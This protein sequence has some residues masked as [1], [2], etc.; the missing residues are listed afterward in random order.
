ME[1]IDIHFTTSGT[2]GEEFYKYCEG[3]L[4]AL[5]IH[6]HLKGKPQLVGPVNRDLPGDVFCESSSPQ[7]A[8]ADTHRRKKGDVADA[9]REFGNQTWREALAMRK[10]DT[11]ERKIRFLEENESR[12]CDSI[13]SEKTKRLLYK[14]T[15][16]QRSTPKYLFAAR[17]R[18]R[19]KDPQG[20]SRGDRYFEVEETT[21]V[22]RSL[23]MMSLG[24]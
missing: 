2:N 7:E 16:C 20:H 8:G 14:I 9:I 6:L 24:F 22:G 11:E 17:K 12:A 18:G 3:L 1:L 5:Y 15:L 13:Y 10:H 19:S 4:D 23:T 21:T